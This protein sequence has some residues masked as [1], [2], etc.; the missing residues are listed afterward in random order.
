MFKRRKGKAPED[1]M[2][3]EKQGK[4]KSKDKR[5]R[6]TLSE[7]S[8]VHIAMPV[9][10]LALCAFSGI[11]I[12]TEASA[13]VVGN[14]LGG[15][16]F[17]LLG[18]GAY[19]IPP[20]L[21][22]ASIFWRKELKRHALLKK[23]IFGALCLVL[24][25]V[26]FYTFGVPLESK[27]TISVFWKLGVQ[28]IGGG[29]LGNLIGLPF[30]LT[31]GKVGTLVFVLLLL[32]LFC[33]LFLRPDLYRM[34]RATF[35]FFS[36]LAKARKE[37]RERNAIARAEAE[38]Q[39]REREEDEANDFYTKAPV[40]S[41][42]V[43]YDPQS[44]DLRPDGSNHFMLNGETVRRPISR[45]FYDASRDFED[46]DAAETDQN[47]EAET[48]PTAKPFEDEAFFST[49]PD[50]YAGV[51]VEDIP[52][53]SDDADYGKPSAATV[54]NGDDSFTRVEFVAD[55]PIPPRPEKRQP[56]EK[57]KTEDALEIIKEESSEEKTVLPGVP[58]HIDDVLNE[59]KEEGSDESDNVSAS[60]DTGF[61]INEAHTIEHAGVDTFTDEAEEYYK[62][63]NADTFFYSFPPLSL[64]HEEDSDNRG[65]SDEVI[66]EK[67][68]KLMQ[69]LES[70]GVEARISC[71]SR[72]PRLTR[73][74]LV[75]KPG[76]KIRSIENLVNE[77]A[78]NLEA[79]SVR[80]E[81]PIPGK[82]ALGIE[83]PNTKTSAVRLR[84][85]LDTD[86]FRDS[87][88]KTT[89]CLGVDVVGT[90]VFADLDK[91]P[92]L[93]VAGATGMGKSVCINS[94]LISLLYKATPDEVKLILIDP[95]K[96]EFKSYYNIPHLLVPVVTE[97][98][99]A[100]GALSWAV[101]EMERRYDI[102]ERVGVRNIKAYNAT[103]AS[104]PEREKLTQIV[105]VI[106]E[107]YD[108]MIQAKDAI[109]DSIGRIA[110]KARAA[111]IILIIGTQRPSVNV[112]TGVIKANIPSR[113]A[114][115]VAS[116]VDSRTILDAVGA[117][118]LLDK[119]DMLFLS[120][121]MQ[122][123]APK[124]VQGAF[125]DDDEVACV[126]EYLRKNSSGVHYDESI[127]ADIDRESE[128]YNKE[129]RTA[130]DFPIS[131]DEC[132]GGGSEAELLHRAIEVAIESGKISTSHLQRKLSIGFGK[133]ARLIDRMEEMGIVGT[134]NGNK[135][136]EILVTMD[137]YHAMRL[138]QDE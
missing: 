96:V 120:P 54:T 108:L 8:A 74:E 18:S 81:A 91:M 29:I 131:A 71:V 87:P 125:L 110:A 119:G 111:G 30:F 63:K 41:M 4:V 25:S 101:N 53:E 13:G 93:L 56:A 113:I 107:L 57:R 2:N 33:V 86:T 69:T 52:Q 11:C 44:T 94:I 98:Q 16:F 116:Q 23:A 89:V 64:L 133:A 85:L 115:H 58:E 76:V 126:A 20:L 123:M 100:A 103:L 27:R 118:K 38:R 80:I 104:H 109:E 65:E 48:V 124:R 73:Y 1:E 43:R 37:G 78:M 114:F 134:S 32:A 82:A 55:K 75:P 59:R 34:G 136:R 28:K 137:E 10:M 49:V 15:F 102:I 9:I 36:R 17:G 106:D 77:I 130:P 117:E 35:A 24:I 90:P 51:P 12:Y 26:L 127:M 92:H 135:A 19:F 60:S 5:M 45:Q 83:V 6:K 72:G 68:D 61:I 66:A 84:G 95:K 39:K 21:L 128:K 22:L 97:A 132:E 99:K 105:I 3:E 7:N 88:G 47:T 79:I 14:W 121:G 122:M 42:P 67:A 46:D 129:K 70:F 40:P 62:S 50:G 31:V 138:R 112:I